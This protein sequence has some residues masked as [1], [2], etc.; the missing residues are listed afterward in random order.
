MLTQNV[1]GMVVAR[2]DNANGMDSK[3]NNSSAN[4]MHL[5][6]QY[7]AQIMKVAYN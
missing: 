3:R 7:K 5:H 1:H 4:L 2:A 6:S